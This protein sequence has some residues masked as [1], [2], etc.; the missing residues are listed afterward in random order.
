ME[1]ICPHN[2]KD[3]YIWKSLIFSFSFFFSTLC[4]VNVGGATRLVSD[5]LSISEKKLKS[6]I[7]IIVNTPG[8]K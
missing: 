6:Q 7:S 2:L 3:L 8:N 5:A 4:I 1:I